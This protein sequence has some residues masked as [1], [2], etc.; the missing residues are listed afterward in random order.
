MDS[1]SSSI[2]AIKGGLIIGLI[3]IIITMLTYVVDVSLM[4]DWK[5]SLG[6]FAVSI[7]LFVFIGKKYRNEYMEG[8]IKF[9]EAFRFIFI[10]AI[11]SSILSGFFMILL[12]NFIDPELPEI[13]T[14]KVL[15][16]TEAMM[17]TFGTP[18]EA[19]D[20]AMEQVEKDLEGKF[21]VGGILA[22]SW[23]WLIAAAFYALIAGAII[24]KS[25]PEFDN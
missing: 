23:A 13:I 9:G 7:F 6:L 8:F 20:E 11:C 5:F 19:M 1:N 10:A 25:K 2:A 24:K 3:S 4:V 14:E 15:Q 17:E 12:Y 16:N 18:T 21:S 22:G